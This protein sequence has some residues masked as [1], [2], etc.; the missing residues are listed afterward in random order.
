MAGVITE[1]VTGIT[2]EAVTGVTTEAVT[3][4][5]TEAVTGVTTVVGEA[6][7]S[8]TT[9]TPSTD[10]TTERKVTCVS[11]MSGTAAYWSYG[12]EIPESCYS[13][14]IL[15]QYAKYGYNH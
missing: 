1:A 3:G 12:Y 15:L 13:K 11:W 2:T 7:P 14:C 9:A 4:V 8:V 10:L 6:T 5:T